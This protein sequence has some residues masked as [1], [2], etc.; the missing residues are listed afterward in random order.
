MLQVWQREFT[1]RCCKS[2]I[3]NLHWD[4]D[5]EVVVFF[6]CFFCLHMVIGTAQDVDWALTY[7][8][9]H[10]RVK[11]ILT[12][13][14]TLAYFSLPDSAAMVFTFLHF[15]QR[16]LGSAFPCPATQHTESVNTQYCATSAQR[17][18]CVQNTGGLECKHTVLCYNYSALSFC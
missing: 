9:R 15:L 8:A 14:G 18:V 16:L 4:A 17:W 11:Q 10:S 13:T 3:E 2:D 5:S 7:P 1:L 12:D 6:V